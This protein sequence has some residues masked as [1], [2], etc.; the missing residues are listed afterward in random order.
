MKKLIAIVL[1]GVS[2]SA[3]AA[4]NAPTFDGSN[5]E[6]SL[7]Y[8]GMNSVSYSADG[9]IYVI[10]NYDP[11]HDMPGG[12]WKLNKVTGCWDKLDKK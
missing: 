5:Q 9:N 4:C 2:V 11:T 10:S 1:F 6:V 8:A 12:V 3:F 7:Q